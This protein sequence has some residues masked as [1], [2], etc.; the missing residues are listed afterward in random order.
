MI[1]PELLHKSDVQVYPLGDLGYFY[2]G[3]SGKSKEDFVNGNM[4]FIPYMNIFS[5]LSIDTDNLGMVKVEPGERQN[6]V[7]YGDFLFTASSETPDECGMS[8]VMLD[9]TDWNN[10]IFLNSFCFGFRFTKVSMIY[11]PFYKHLF[12]SYKIRKAISRTANGVTRFNIS[13][14]AFAR[15]PI[16]VPPIDCQRVLADKLDSFTLL[17]SDIKSEIRMRKLQFEYIKEYCFDFDK[18]KVLS[19]RIG[20][21]FEFKNGL[22]KEKAFFGAGNPI[23]NYT[24]VYHNNFITRDLLK[25]RVTLNQNEIERFRVLRGDVFFT[26][27]S[28]TPDEVGMAS[29]LLDD[30]S[31]C[32]FSGFLLRARP[33]TDFLLPEYCKYCFST[34]KVRSDIIRLSTYTT[35]ALTNG[36]SLS[37]IEIPVPSKEEQIKIVSFLDTFTSLISKLEEELDLRQKQYEYYREKLLTFE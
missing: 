28:E 23:I 32:T 35:R 10:P 2:G 11:P 5:N 8:S 31:D 16:P 4:R 33:I 34:T 30:I 20:D 14:K 37:R 1:H 6:V 24:D 17:I 7:E 22:N 18:D 36:R 19:K 15:I 29:V 25:G 3:L 27:T 12:R 26:R 9:K 21:L 13:K